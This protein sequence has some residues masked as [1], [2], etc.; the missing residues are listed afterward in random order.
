MTAQF[1]PS[2]YSLLL[3]VTGTVAAMMLVQLLIADVA[4][5]RAGK[6]AGSTVET[7]H[8]SFLFRATRAIGNTNESV[9]IFMLTALF[10][11]G[12]G[13]APD[14]TNLAA[15]G[16]LF[17]RLGHMLFYY[18]NIGKLRS[19]AFGFSIVSLVVMLGAGF[20]A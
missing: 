1:F 5:L 15:C 10:C 14:V 2:D 4:G 3:C 6:K 12:V 7:D 19:I 16:Y 9:A 13:A 11:V 8:S 18:L 20:V 17:G